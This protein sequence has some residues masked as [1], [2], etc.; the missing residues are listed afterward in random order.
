[1]SPLEELL[2]KSCGKIDVKL[3]EKQIWQFMAY[4]IC[5]WSGTKK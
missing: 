3:D 1:M 4:K 5:F 2:F